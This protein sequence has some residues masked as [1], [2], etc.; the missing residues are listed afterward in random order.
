MYKTKN[1]T[2]TDLE[3]LKEQVANVVAPVTHEE[4]VD[5]VDHDDEREI[6][7]AIEE[8]MSDGRI[9]FTP[10]GAGFIPDR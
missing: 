7:G 4:I 6:E 2:Q 8:L 5:A 1:L 3:E 9:R 10:D